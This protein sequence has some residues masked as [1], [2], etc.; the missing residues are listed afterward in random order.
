MSSISS[1]K[2][3]EE[4]MAA[5]GFRLLIDRPDGLYTY[6]VLLSERDAATGEI[7]YKTLVRGLGTPAHVRA[8]LEKEQL[9]ENTNVFIETEDNHPQRVDQNPVSHEPIELFFDL[10]PEPEVEL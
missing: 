1:E 2:E 4:E 8:F 5:A 6:N 7:T 9:S 3:F 10:R